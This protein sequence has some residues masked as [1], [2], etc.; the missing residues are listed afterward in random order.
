MA[1][2]QGQRPP[3]RGGCQRVVNRHILPYPDLPPSTTPRAP[4]TQLPDIPVPDADG[5]ASIIPDTAAGGIPG[6]GPVDLLAYITHLLE[7]ALAKGRCAA[8][9]VTLDFKHAS[10]SV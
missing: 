2:T 5:G 6:K 1:Q 3:T 9:V 4:E 7:L 10:P 8:V